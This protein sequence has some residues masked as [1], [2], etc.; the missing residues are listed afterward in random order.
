DVGE[1]QATRDYSRFTGSATLNFTSGEMDLYGIP[2]TITQRAVVGVDKAWDV[3]RQLFPLEDGNVPANLQQYPPYASGSSW[4][5]VY[6]ETV[7]GQM[8]YE[9]PIQGN[10]SFDYA[11]TIG[12]D[13]ADMFSFN[14]AIGAQ[15]YSDTSDYFA[16]DGTGFAST[17]S[18]TINQLS[19]S[20]VSTDYS[21]VE[22]KS[23]GFYVQEEIGYQDRLFLTGALRF[24]DNST[25]GV[26]APAQKYPK[27]SGTWV[28]SEESFWNVGPVNSLRLRGAWGKAGRQ[29][30]ATAGSNIYVAMTGPG[31]Q[32]AVRPAS[33]GNPL[34]G[35]EVSTELEVGADVAFF[36]DRISGEFTYYQR[37]DRD[38]LLSIPLFDSFG[39]PGSVASNLGDINNW[40]WEAQLSTR[41]W[42]GAGMAFDLDM[43]ADYTN[44][45]IVDL[46]DYNTSD[47]NIRI[48][49]PYPNQTEG[50]V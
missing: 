18:T 38:A 34:I 36:D 22:N 29:P 46:G 25:F 13:V 3:D 11:A 50:D 7:D 26:D 33:P 23:L 47:A 10:M 27:F 42:E 12:M 24:D 39:F 48:G 35:P 6:S 31:G 9:R 1:V 14:T 40:G 49:W 19:Q 20:T 41:V 21:F 8:F 28:I 15:Y 16:N 4:A 44:N 43:S 37:E 45:E 2:T 17:L 32:A 30:S 5:A